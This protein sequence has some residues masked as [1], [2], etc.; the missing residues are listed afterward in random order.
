MKR[1]EEFSGD[2]NSR[3]LLVYLIA[4]CGF[5]VSSFVDGLNSG[6]VRFPLAQIVAV[7]LVSGIATLFVLW[8]GL[9]THP[10]WIRL[11]G[12]LLLGIGFADG[13]KGF[14]G[15]TMGWAAA[16]IGF[17]AALPSFTFWVFGSRL[18][19][20][21][22]AAEAES[23]V[24]TGPRFTLRQIFVVTAAVAIAALLLRGLFSPESGPVFGAQV[25]GVLA[26]VSLSAPASAIAALGRRN[27]IRRSFA[28]AG[29]F[30]IVAFVFLELFPNLA[31]Q[32]LEIVAWAMLNLLFSAGALLLY[33]R[34][35]FRLVHAQRTSG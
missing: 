24:A 1:S 32:P 29:L 8:V 34:I 5:F 20:F 10:A 28:V 18:V 7:S 12:A 19:K 4:V 21:S 30:G 14:L 6:N 35:G 23:A 11:T 26:V 25:L 17:I 33:R 31:E 16:S 27:P 15:L 9:G 3:A 22:S 13:P 2:G